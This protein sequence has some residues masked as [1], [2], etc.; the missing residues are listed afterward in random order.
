MMTA[1]GCVPAGRR[2]RRG[3]VAARE[4]AMRD[5][6]EA[7]GRLTAQ[8]IDAVVDELL[9]LRRRSESGEQVPTPLVTLH[10][11]SGRD[12][13]GYL[14][15]RSNAGA[16][17]EAW[18]VHVPGAARNA[19]DD[20]VAYVP[21]AAVEALTVHGAGRLALAVAAL[22]PPPSRLELS[23]RAAELGRS[24]SERAHH[25]VAVEVDWERLPAGD[26]VLKALAL[27]L[28]RTGRALACSD[29]ALSEVTRVRLVAE[30]GD[31]RR[32]GAALA[33]PV[34]A[35]VDGNLREALDRLLEVSAPEAL[36]RPS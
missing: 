3:Q 20:D 25:G 12:L 1:G 13:V 2:G 6:I 26:E 22:A 14:M 4:D 36:R 34:A 16:P 28:D 23:R 30:G 19:G 33:I 31:V 32:D 7:L 24:L 9:A 5:A 18:L 17:G 35:G 8:S 27:A 15:A 10:L 21:P 11:R 29:H